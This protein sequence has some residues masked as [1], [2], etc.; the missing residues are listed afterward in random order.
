MFWKKEKINAQLFTIETENRRSA[1]R[2]TPLDSEPVLIRIRDNEIPLN[3]ISAT[4]ICFKSF[5]FK[6]RNKDWVEIKL[7]G[8]KQ[9]AKVEIEIVTISETEVCRCRFTAIEKVL[10]ETIHQYVLERQKFE[11]RNRRF[12][13]PEAS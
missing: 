13:R 1:F 8:M 5:G 4:G 6:A 11:I 7:P 3:N 12:G 2:V 9:W 10:E